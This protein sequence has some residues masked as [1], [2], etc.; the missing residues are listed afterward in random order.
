MFMP[1]IFLCLLL[2]S[3][4]YT[5]FLEGVEANLQHR[6]RGLLGYGNRL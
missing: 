5:T 2:S 6:C 1:Y 4:V 3:L